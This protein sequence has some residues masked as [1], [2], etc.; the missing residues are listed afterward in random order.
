MLSIGEKEEGLVVQYLAFGAFRHFFPGLAVVSETRRPTY[1]ASGIHAGAGRLAFGWS[2]KQFADLTMIFVADHKVDSCSRVYYHNHHG[3][4]WHYDGHEQGCPR[5]TGYFKE[6]QLSFYMDRF[7]ETLARA[8]TSVRPD[9]FVVA[10]STSSSCQLVHSGSVPSTFISSDRFTNMTEVLMTEHPHDC[11]LP[12]KA[13]TLLDRKTVVE[14]IRNGSMTGF[15]TI[16]GGSEMQMTHDTEASANFGFCV[17]NYSVSPDQVS[18]YTKSQIDDFHS[19]SVSVGEYL[20]KQPSRTVNSGTFHSEETV[21]TTYL[22][23]LMEARG[24]EGFDITHLMLYKF[25]DWSSDFLTPVLQARHDYKRA[26]NA[27]AAECL[28]LVGNGSFGYNGL[29]SSNYSILKLMTDET[30]RRKRAT[31]M[32][33]LEIRHLT[34]IGLVKIEKKERKTKKKKSSKNKTS[35]APQGRNYFAVDEASVADDDDDDD[36][37]DEEEEDDDDDDDDVDEDD[38][39]R[40]MERVLGVEE[41][42]DVRK[43]YKTC[44]LYAMELPG[45][46]RQVFNNI[47]KAVAILSNSKKLFLSHVNVMMQCLDPRLAELCYIDTDS[48]IWSQTYPSLDDCLRPEKR[49]MWLSSGIIA[50]EEGELSCHGKMKLEGLFSGGQFKTMKIYRLYKNN[51]VAYTRCKGINRAIGERLPENC[52]DPFCLHNYAVHRT[53]LRPTKTGEIV[54]A[55]ENRHLAIPFNLKRHVTQDGI[56]TLP[57]S[58][59]LTE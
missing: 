56:H 29:E 31:S 24:F 14:K 5:Y 35:N 23:W 27:V 48:C 22:K 18:D 45:N 19:G 11:W 58:S 37:D 34:M 55:H 4:H 59:C 21:S 33:G 42:A 39:N 13:T 28:K 17:Q 47:A 3:A 15:V 10:Y 50:N 46:T 20:K 30:V 8:L 43:S 26:G 7:R 44:F 25:T 49:A 32:K 52:F 53:T 2:E 36:D 40:E 12:L 16:K 54:V 51:D 41:E 6:N 9:K 57:F 38:E 1:I